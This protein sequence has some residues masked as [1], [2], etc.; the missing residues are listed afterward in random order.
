MKYLQLENYEVISVSFITVTNAIPVPND[1][2]VRFRTYTPS[3]ME[4]GTILTQEQIDLFLQKDIEVTARKQKILDEITSLIGLS[5]LSL[6]DAQRWKLIA[7]VFYK[8]G[9][10]SSLGIVN[11]YSDWLDLHD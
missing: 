7:A 2:E 5:V 1:F 10:I 6:T 9:V 4:P 11:Q 8:L 3:G